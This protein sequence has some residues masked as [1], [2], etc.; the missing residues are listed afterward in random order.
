MRAK[1][2]RGRERYSAP[3]YMLQCRMA[4]RNTGLL[5]RYSAFVPPET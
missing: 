2:Q 4:R 3:L 1:P 5:G